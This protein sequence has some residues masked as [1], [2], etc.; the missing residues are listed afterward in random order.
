MIT[1]RGFLSGGAKAALGLACAGLSLHTS[2]PI[3]EKMLLDAV[4]AGLPWRTGSD[5][6]VRL[7]NYRNPL[8]IH[9][10]RQGV[11]SPS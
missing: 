9:F 3:T 2:T 8:C 11:V 6:I 5:G 7:L 1:R 4:N 10:H